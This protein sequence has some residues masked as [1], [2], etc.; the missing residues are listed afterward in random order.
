MVI[1]EE[2]NGKWN[3]PAMW[4]RLYN[5]LDI[6]ERRASIKAFNAQQKWVKRGLAMIPTKFGIAYTSKFMNQGGALVHLY[7]DGTVL[8][9]HGGTEMVSVQSLQLG[10]LARVLSGE[11]M[12]RYC[13]FR[14]RDKAYTLKC[15]KLPHKRLEYH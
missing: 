9:S 4:S 10:T 13:F 6:E 5:E 8:V 2:L 11:L 3:I 15:A 1:G 12:T 7:K 14:S